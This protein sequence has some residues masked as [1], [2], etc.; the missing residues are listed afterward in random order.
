MQKVSEKQVN[1]QECRVQEQKTWLWLPKT[2][3]GLKT[4]WTTQWDMT[5]K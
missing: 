5:E 2:Y 1:L 4:D 3:M